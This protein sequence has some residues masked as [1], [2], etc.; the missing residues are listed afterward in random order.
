MDI[1]R[2]LNNYDV[3]TRGIYEEESLEDVILEDREYID[4][5]LERDD[6]HVDDR[7]AIAEALKKLEE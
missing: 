5:L 1:M 3:F 6:L 7:E 2:F 4:Y